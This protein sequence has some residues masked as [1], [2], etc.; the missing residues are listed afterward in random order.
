MTPRLA[1]VEHHYTFGEELANSITHGVALVA[2]IAVLPVLIIT[3]VRA[4]DPR[5]VV[6]ASVFGA[7]LVLLYASSTLY[8]AIPGERLRRTKDVCQ[9]IDH[10]AIY[11]LIAGS[12]TP[13]MLVTLRGAWGWS[14]FGVVWGLAFVGILLKSVFGA[15]HFNAL[16]TAVYLGMGWL[17]VI[18]I[19][20]LIHAAEP[21]ALVLLLVGGVMYSGGVV[22][23]VW[24][25][26][27]SHAV[28]HLFVMAGSAAHAWAILGYVLPGKG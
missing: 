6:A 16:S 25:R 10:S 14:L 8:H 11:L 7:V 17:A 28:W 2:S 21:A 27:Y 20:P 19:R 5:R 9:R 15:R 26:R 22:F 24:Q 1:G 3:A 13:F 4:H 18:A 12:Y 23:Y